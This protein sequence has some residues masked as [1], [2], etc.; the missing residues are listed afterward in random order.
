MDFN[1]SVRYTLSA[2]ADRATVA[3]V[4]SG[5]LMSTYTVPVGKFD[6]ALGNMIG[7]YKTGKFK[8]AIILLTPKSNKPC[9]E[10]A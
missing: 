5:S 3:S 9:C 6:V 8:Q 7:Y 4:M 1:P 2:S 10:M